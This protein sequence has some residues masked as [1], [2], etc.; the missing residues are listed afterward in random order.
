MPADNPMVS[1]IVP[2]VSGHVRFAS[3]LVRSLNES[4]YRLEE[5]IIV[6]S[7][8]SQ[9]EL[10]RLRKSLRRFNGGQLELID[11]PLA[12]AGTNRNLGISVARGDFLAFMDADDLFARDRLRILINA[13]SSSGAAAAVH[14]YSRFR[15]GFV[16]ALKMSLCSR[17]RIL[18]KGAA[19]AVSTLKA[20]S[21]LDPNLK[22]TNIHASRLHHAHVLV[23][24]EVAREIRF[25]DTVDRNE[26]ALFLRAVLGSGYEISFVNKKLSAYCLGSRIRKGLTR[27]HEKLIEARDF[28]E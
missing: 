24:S 6:G 25:S 16:G 17:A 15:L 2:I 10:S 5:L 8:L 19:D 28:P 21:L 7:G 27:L 12:P 26:D 22:G 23:R 20:H 3:R 11:A 14:T 18:T 13:L 4:D 1:G 9:S